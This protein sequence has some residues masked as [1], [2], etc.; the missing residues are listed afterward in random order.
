MYTPAQE[1]A[2]NSIEKLMKMLM[3]IHDESFTHLCLMFLIKLLIVCHAY[4][5]RHLIMKNARFLLISP[6]FFVLFHYS[7]TAMSSKKKKK[8]ADAPRLHFTFG[9]LHFPN[10]IQH[11][12]SG[13]FDSQ[14]EHMET[15]LIYSCESFQHE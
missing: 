2:L 5:I 8:T 11:F 12:Y 14:R 6:S 7:P 13:N 9:S 10:I 15:V 4:K 3:H 1:A